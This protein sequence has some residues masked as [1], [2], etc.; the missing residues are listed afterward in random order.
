MRPD[1]VRLVRAYRQAE[2]ATEETWR[3][4]MGKA[5]AGQMTEEQ[6]IR[7]AAAVYAAQ[8][9]G[10]MAAAEVLRDAAAGR[11]PGEPAHPTDC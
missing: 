10:A 2:A 7:I 3:L 11:E 9:G 1:V 8:E 6:V 4:V 5:Y